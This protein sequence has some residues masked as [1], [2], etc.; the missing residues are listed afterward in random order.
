[1]S[2]RYVKVDITQ[3]TQPQSQAGYGLALVLSTEKDAEYKEYSSGTALAAIDKEYGVDSETYKLAS[4]VLNQ[5]PKVDKIAVVG[6]Q[7]DSGT[8]ATT[9]L[10]AALNELTKTRNDFFYLVSTEQGKAEIEALGAWVASKMKF[11]FATTTKE[12]FDTLGE[13]MPRNAV[14]MV[15]DKPEQYA[16]EALVGA[17]AP[18]NIGSYTITFQ[19]LIGISPVLYDS[20]DIDDI[21]AKGGITYI[22]DGG[23]NIVSAGR[24]M[25]NEYFD[26]VQG[27]FYLKNRLTENVFNNVLTRGKTKVPYSQ[28]G[29]NTVVAEVDATLGASVESLTTGEGIIAR[30]ADG[31]PEYFVETPLIENISN[32]DKSNRRLPGVNWRA[33]VAGAVESVKINGVMQL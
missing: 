7:Y 33:T 11:Y 14:V 9:Q 3:E 24:T 22:R 23:K 16:G 1:M 26:L 17:I 19:N 15:H 30:D 20:M 18:L 8:E 29:I 32:A 13:N 12:V 5:T 2:N 6:V 10:V 21:E 27:E 25:G 31:N 28:N 4:A